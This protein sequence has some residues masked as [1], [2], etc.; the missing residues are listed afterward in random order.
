VCAPRKPRLAC[1]EAFTRRPCRPQLLTGRSQQRAFVL[2]KPIIRAHDPRHQP[3]VNRRIKITVL[4]Q[5]Q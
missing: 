2:S 5:M 1:A 3:G 4:H